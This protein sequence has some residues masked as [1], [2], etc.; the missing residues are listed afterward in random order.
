MGSL[1]RPHRELSMKLEEIYRH[2]FNVFETN[3]LIKKK[4]VEKSHRELQQVYEILTFLYAFPQNVMRI[5]VSSIGLSSLWYA[6][7]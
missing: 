2:I 1:Q 5:V 6:F 4:K 3:F 7:S